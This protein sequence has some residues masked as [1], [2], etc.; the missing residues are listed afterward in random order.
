MPKQST[1]IM[2][3]GE[4]LSKE[5]APEPVTTIRLIM[6]PRCFAG[7]RILTRAP[8]NPGEK[9][10]LLQEVLLTWMEGLAMVPPLFSP[11]L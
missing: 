4:K 2:D 10:A 7:M 5:I 11:Y 8:E 1:L 6:N 9:G 3:Q